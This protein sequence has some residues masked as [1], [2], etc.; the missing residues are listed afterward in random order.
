MQ[1]LNRFSAFLVA[2]MALLLVQC[3][4]QFLADYDPIA[5][6]QITDLQRTVDGLFYDLSANITTPKAN[7]QNYQAVYKTIFVNLTVLA[8]RVQLIPQNDLMVRQVALLQDAIKQLQKL[9]QLGFRNLAQLTLAQ[10]PI[11]TIFQ[12][13]LRLELAEKKRTF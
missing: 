12:S 6:Q 13:I 7:Y 3:S 8:T 10:K 5:D 11:D 4:I 1:Y 2:S 9:H